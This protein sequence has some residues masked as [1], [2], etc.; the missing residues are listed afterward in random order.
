MG[1]KFTREF[2][3]KINGTLYRVDLLDSA[4]SGT[5]T[6]M[7]HLFDEGVEIQ[8]E[9]QGDERHETIKA[10]QAT[11]FLKIDDSTEGLALETWLKATMLNNNEDRYH[12]AIY[13]DGSLY[14]YGVML[15]D[16]HSWPNKPYPYKWSFRATDGLKRLEAYRFDY[17]VTRNDL[18]KFTTLIHE[19][20]K[21]TPFY[22][23]N[24]ISVMF[25]TL[26]DWYE[27]N[28]PTVAA[29]TD[30]LAQSRVQTFVFTEIDKNKVRIGMTYYEVLK[31]ILEH[32]VCS[33]KLSDGIFRIIQLNAQVDDATTKYERFYST[34][35]G[36]YVSASVPNYNLE[37]DQENRFALEGAQF[38]N[39]PPIHRI[40]L[41][42][43]FVNKNKLNELTSFPYTQVLKQG[44]VGGTT[45]RL[46]FA[47][48]LVFQL[49]NATLTSVYTIEFKIRIILPKTG[50]TYYLRKDPIGAG[51]SWTTVSTDSVFILH[52]FQSIGTIP[53]DIA[54][55]FTTPAIPSGVYNAATFSIEVASVTDNVTGL[56]IFDFNVARLE[57]ST[58]LLYTQSALGDNENYYEYIGQNTVDTINSYD[59]ELPDAKIGEMYDA[60]YDGFLYTGSN[61]GVSESTGLWQINGSGPAYDFN[62]IRVR[63]I[64]SGQTLP[65]RKYQGT[66]RSSQIL[67]HSRIEYDGKVWI[68]NGA[69]FKLTSEQV[70]GE[71]FAISYDRASYESIE[72]ATSQTGDGPVGDIIR[73]QGAAQEGISITKS[74]LRELAGERFFA[75]TSDEIGIG[76]GITSIPIQAVG[77]DNLVLDSDTMRLIP[78]NGGKNIKLTVTADVLATDT[79]ILVSGFD[80]DYVIPAGAIIAYDYFEPVLTNIRLKSIPTSDP[81]IPGK[82]YRDSEGRLYVS[83]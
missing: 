58:Q 39:F 67:P 53:F 5:A 43:P 44:I 34:A 62:E 79:E 56:P 38:E 32:W 18:D 30:P 31:M 27:D 28:M 46:N 71:W 83:L 45:R 16:F 7:P 42:Y 11:V 63:E 22:I 65:T 9:E 73:T 60:A 36:A 37:I 51:Y 68:M 69:T 24:P 52:E 21:K 78:P 48:I 10:S 75:Y 50:T 15:P 19:I 70:D 41:K 4:F 66:F 1:V 47:T 2:R 6:T 29:N 81:G 25:S 12:L 33:I 49:N 14:W 72:S 76:T 54:L 3:S 55:G 40:Y 26:V 23:G 80:T 13:K 74:Q 82:P 77:V 64:L 59:I 8:Y 61:S 20:L 35:S 57:G 17:A